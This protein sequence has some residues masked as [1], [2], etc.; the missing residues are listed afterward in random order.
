MRIVG[1]L[2]PGYDKDRV[3]CNA[4]FDYRPWAIYYCEKAEDVVTAIKAARD[5]GK[6]VRIRSGGHQHEGMCSADDVALIDVSSINSVY[7]QDKQ[8]RVWIGA[9]LALKDV[10]VELW[11]RGYYFPGGACGDVHV[12]GL[13]Q[14]GGWGLGLRNYGLT[15]DS[16]IGVEIVTANGAILEIPRRDRPGDRRRLAALRG[17]GGGNFGVITRF[18]F[19]THP[20]RHEYCDL[21][22]TWGDDELPK[23]SLDV[24]LRRW[25]SA[26][27]HDEDKKLSTFMRVAVAPSGTDDRL[28]LRGRYLGGPSEAQRTLDR[29]ILKGYP[30]PLSIKYTPVQPWIPKGPLRLSGP[31]RERLRER[32]GTH[33]G[34]Q[35]G[36]GNLTSTCAGS[37][38]RHK[39]SSGFVRRPANLNNLASKLISVI[40]NTTPEP[41][42]LARQYVSLHCLGGAV[43]SIRVP[44]AYA[45]RDRDVLLQYQAWW[46]GV[47]LDTKCITWIENFRKSMAP[48]TDGAFINFVDRDIP[49]GEYYK[50]MLPKLLVGVKRNWDPENFFSFGMSIP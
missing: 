45:F 10:Y 40:R 23:D 9:G 7:F 47:A 4:R 8:R 26:F 31:E 12:G 5:N 48:Y 21:A 42:D 24:L 16:L 27:P 39:V 50:D 19:R 29:L 36:P 17:G 34:Y 38:I 46:N 44:S 35:P 13:T 2:E 25:M 41:S 49:L 18:C 20:M 6:F 32:L 37:S 14:G 33:P 43:A 3:I 28:L 1:P 30:K 22:V 15:C 11:R